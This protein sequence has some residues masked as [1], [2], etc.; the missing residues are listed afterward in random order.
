MTVNKANIITAMDAQPFTR[1]DPHL[2]GNLKHVR[3]S[4]EL[5]DQ[6]DGDHTIVLPIPVDAVLT[7]VKFACDDLGS[8]SD[9]ILD[10]TFYKKNA[11][12]TYSEIS[13]GLIANSIDIHTGAVAL[14]EYRYSVLGIQTAK[15]AAWELAGLSARPD[16]GTIYIGVSTDTDNTI[17]ATVLL[18][19]TYL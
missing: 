16:Y 18:E 8:G 14:T 11:D 17:S 5:A 15:Q 1:L 2:L 10:I 19:A 3:D 4:F 7:S 9:E 13:D 6:A 12:G